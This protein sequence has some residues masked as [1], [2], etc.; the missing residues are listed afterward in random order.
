M[1][2]DW[3]LFGILAISL[4]LFHFFRE[5]G[6]LKSTSFNKISYL[7][8]FILNSLLNK[9]VN[10]KLTTQFRDDWEIEIILLVIKLSC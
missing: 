4:K 10:G 6:L 7:D 8:F 3:S 1:F 9:H 5:Y 2:R